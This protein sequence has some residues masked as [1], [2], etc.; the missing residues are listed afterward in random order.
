MEAVGPRRPAE[1]RPDV[2]L[3]AAG[4]G[5]GALLEISAG[6]HQSRSL[7]LVRVH[8]HADHATVASRSRRLQPAVLPDGLF[9]KGTRA[10][11]GLRATKAAAAQQ[12]YTEASPISPV[13]SP[14]S[15]TATAATNAT[16]TADAAGGVRGRLPLLDASGRAR[17]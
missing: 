1:E 4:A 5:Q 9:Q 8:G 7:L 16:P 15:A 13:Q 14:P 3:P 6:G 12:Q 11:R 2:R 10:G 17:A